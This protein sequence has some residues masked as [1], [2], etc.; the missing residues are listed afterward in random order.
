MKDTR[1]DYLGCIDGDLANI[2]SA[3][4]HIRENIGLARQTE[5]KHFVNGATLADIEGDL[6]HIVDFSM[7]AM[8]RMTCV[9]AYEAGN[10]EDLKP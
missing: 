6:R 3:I 7:N 10:C 4:R 8:S 1:R 2:E 5:D 9:H